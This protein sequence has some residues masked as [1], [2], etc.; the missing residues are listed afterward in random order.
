M[1]SVCVLFYNFDKDIVIYFVEWKCGLNNVCFLKFLVLLL[2]DGFVQEG[3]LFIGNIMVDMLECYVMFILNYFDLSGFECGL[4]VVKVEWK[5][6]FGYNNKGWG[7]DNLRYME[8]VKFYCYCFN[9]NVG[10][11]G[12][13][14]KNSRL[15]VVFFID[16]ELLI[17]E[18][19]FD[20]I[21][22]K[23][24]ILKVLLILILFWDIEW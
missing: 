17:F 18:E 21:G 15:F 12:D 3:F 9:D 24:R 19:F 8:Q 20:F 5:L 14:W 6:I 16:L 2:I 4:Y 13:I 11:L 23:F 22:K 1:K 10:F 7:L